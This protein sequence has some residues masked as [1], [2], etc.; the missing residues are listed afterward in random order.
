MP[1]P[2]PQG[3][4]NDAFRD[5]AP[6]LLSYTKSDYFIYYHPIFHNYFGLFLGRLPILIFNLAVNV[7]FNSTAYLH[8]N[9]YY[10]NSNHIFST[11]SLL[12]VVSST[13]YYLIKKKKTKGMNT[14]VLYRPINYNYSSRW[15][16]CHEFQ[17]IFYY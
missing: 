9:F 1:S 16:K 11:L 13:E 2:F 15:Y 5:P 10:S 4:Q 14:F 17:L 6:P 3:E 12:C 7:G 8:I